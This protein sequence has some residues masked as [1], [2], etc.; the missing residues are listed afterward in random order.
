MK[1]I[2]RLGT[3]GSPLALLQAENVRAR[4][5]AA[6]PAL[7]A[8]SEIEIIPIRTSGDWRP[9]HKDKTFLEMGGDKGL[10]TKEIEDALIS[11]VIDMAVHS[12][13]DVPSK[14][15]DALEIATLL[16]RADPHDVFIANNVQTLEELPAGA[17]VG[18][19]SLR[20]QAQ[21]LHHRPD[22][23]VVPLRG[24]VDTRLRKIADG[25]ADATVLALAGMERLGVEDRISSVLETDIML[26]AVAQGALGVEIRRDDGDM[27]RILAMLDCSRTATCI[28]AERAFL[29]GLDGSCHTPIA[30]LAQLEEDGQL[31]LEGLVAKPDGTTI[32]RMSRNG[33]AK[34]AEAL[35]LALAEE[36]KSRMPIGFFDSP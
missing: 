4:L 19:A 30:G 25:E 14:L 15:P 6:D 35:G 34:D 21:I 10:F 8:E 1:K 29:L 7:R 31:S 28:K 24:N 36:L 11:C 12:M 27:R 16:E 20:R 22:L 9:E 32:I 13:K 33:P 2:L 18:T 26:P 17:V 23:R 3:R 5:L